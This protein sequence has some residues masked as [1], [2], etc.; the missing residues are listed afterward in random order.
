LR[1]NEDTKVGVDSI[2]RKDAERGGGNNPGE[3]VKK[4]KNRQTPGRGKYG[5]NQRGECE[6]S[7]P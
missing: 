7:V 4:K 3:L 6:T 2:S 5:G 1:K